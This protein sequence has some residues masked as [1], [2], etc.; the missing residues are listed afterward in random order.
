[1]TS[2]KKV[3]KSVLKNIPYK[4]MKKIIDKAISYIKKS[5][6]IKDLFEENELPIDII[7][8]IP[9]MFKDIDTSAKTEGGVIYL[10]FKLLEDKDFYKD[11]SYLAHEITHFIQQCFGSKATTSGKEQ[12][13]DNKF[14]VDGFKQQVK[15]IEE[16]FGSDKA[17]RYTDE[18][19]EYHKYKTNKKDKKEELMSDTQLSDKQ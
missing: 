12:Y 11:Y 7:D 4:H 18:L 15:F 9:I 16:E 6:T 17:E 5:D 3:S 14:E 13:L 10:S 8:N 2:S 19:L 1:M